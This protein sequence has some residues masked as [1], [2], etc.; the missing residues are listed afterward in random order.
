MSRTFRANWGSLLNLNDSSRWGCSLCFFQ[1]RC[2]VAGLTF[3]LGNLTSLGLGLLFLH[4]FTAYATQ[5]TALLFGTVL[6]TILFLTVQQHIV[7][8]VVGALTLLDKA[9]HGNTVWRR[10]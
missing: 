4:F 8:A 9:S 7:A 2:T 10:L 5:A 3:W 1:I 6:G